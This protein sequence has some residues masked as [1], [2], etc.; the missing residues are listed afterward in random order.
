MQQDDDNGTRR[1]RPHRLRPRL[2]GIRAE[3]LA[4]R[5]NNSNIFSPQDDLQLESGTSFDLSAA[6]ALF[7]EVVDHRYS[8]DMMDYR[9]RNWRSV[10]TGTMWDCIFGDGFLLIIIKCLVPF[11]S[12]KENPMR[13]RDSVDG[14]YDWRKIMGLRPVEE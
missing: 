13:W 9:D 1:P 8:V 3:C 12:C 5:V 11:C 10:N 14:D 2:L 4:C 7:H 6:R